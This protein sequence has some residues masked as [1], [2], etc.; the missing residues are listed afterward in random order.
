MTR[1]VNSLMMVAAIYVAAVVSTSKLPIPGVRIVAAFIT[2]FTLTAFAMVVND[3]FDVEADKVNEPSRPLPSGEATVRG[4]SVEAFALAVAGMV[5]SFADGKIEF[6][7]AAASVAIS[8]AYSSRLKKT[9]FAG[10]LA[11]SY[12]VALPFLYGGIVAGG[13]KPVLVVFFALAFLS[14]TGREVI[15]GIAEVGGDAVM[16][17]RTLARTHGRETASRVAAFFSLLAVA[18]SPLPI[19]LKAVSPLGYG[20]PVAFTDIFFV[21]LVARLLAKP[22]E[23]GEVKKLYKL[24]MLTAL[25]SFVSGVLL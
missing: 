10:N 22:G 16:D 19:L 25:I 21:Y 2:A 14:N 3:V 20:I 24:P 7:L 17:V 12:N 4:A 6:I 11:V 15:K 13:V 18:L 5:F 9:G 23:A 8:Y 1:P